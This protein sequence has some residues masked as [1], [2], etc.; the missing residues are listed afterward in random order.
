MLTSIRMGAAFWLASALSV[1]LIARIVPAG[2]NQNYLLELAVCLA[3]ATACGLAATALDFGGWR[4]SDWRAILFVFLGT[5]SVIGA[6]R[7]V[8]LART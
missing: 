8:Q 1:F 4:E 3:A 6:Q 2:R 5:A 7:V